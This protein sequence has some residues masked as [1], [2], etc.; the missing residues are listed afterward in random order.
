MIPVNEE[1][2]L[3]LK[4]MHACSEIFKMEVIEVA[5]KLNIDIFATNWSEI[6]GVVQTL[7]QDDWWET[8]IEN[9]LGE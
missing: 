8:P 1:F 6:Q 9:L 5:V 3:C 2:G 7:L 4:H